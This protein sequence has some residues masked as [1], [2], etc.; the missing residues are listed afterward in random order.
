MAINYYWPSRAVARYL[1]IPWRSRCAALC[2]VRRRRWWEVISVV[3]TQFSL[4]HMEVRVV[5]RF[6]F[7]LIT[8]LTTG[9]IRSPYS[10]RDTHTHTFSLWVV[11]IWLEVRF[12]GR[13]TRLLFR[14]SSAPIKYLQGLTRQRT[15]TLN[16]PLSLLLVCIFTSAQPT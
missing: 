4:T 5:R 2:H 16:L 12:S 8:F 11:V 9:I 1:V 14:L 13:W 15:I 10:S 3:A 6:H 7:C